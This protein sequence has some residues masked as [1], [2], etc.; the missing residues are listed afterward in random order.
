MKN[1]KFLL[2]INEIIKVEGSI[3]N[4]PVVGYIVKEPFFKRKYNFLQ[5][6]YAGSN[7]EALNRFGKE[8]GVSK[9]WSFNIYDNGVISSNVIITK[10]LSKFENIK[11]GY[12]HN[13]RELNVTNTSIGE[14]VS[15][16]SKVILLKDE[17]N[18]FNVYSRMDEEIPLFSSRNHPDCCG[19]K[20]LY[21]FNN[22]P[23]YN[24]L[25]E[26]DYLNLIDYLNLNKAA[27]IAHITT[28]QSEA[29]KFVE[30]L[31]FTK[32]Y[33]YINGNSSNTIQVYHFNPSTHELN[34]ENLS[35]LK[36]NNLKT[37]NPKKV[38]IKDKPIKKRGVIPNNVLDSYINHD[39][40]NN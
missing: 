25:I 38:L 19:A 30:N 23:I 18:T 24:K 35:K 14:R 17:N 7:T 8:Y 9:A 6:T 11:D 20:I 12:I 33:T 29:T 27:K 10:I 16:S 28:L 15:I 40:R 1:L 39:T 3:M 22:K 21:G 26:K 13:E 36:K 5:N 34:K 37:Q 32:E 4:T 2:S 31:G